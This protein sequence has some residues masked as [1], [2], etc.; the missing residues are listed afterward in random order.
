MTAT[1]PRLDISNPHPIY[2]FLAKGKFLQ[3]KVFLLM[4]IFEGSGVVVLV[5]P[6]YYIELLEL[7]ML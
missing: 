5:F 3:Q 6:D 2:L 7:S 1:P 4:S